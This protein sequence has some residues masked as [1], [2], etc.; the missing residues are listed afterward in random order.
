MPR[1]ESEPRKETRLNSPYVKAARYPSEQTAG[2]AYFLVQD[3]IFSVE[4]D[5]STY[6]IQLPRGVWHVA[7]VGIT[8]LAELDQKI[9]AIIST[10][11][12]A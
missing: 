5:L 9:T 8:P 6:R 2:K 7:V 12:Q 4:C 11:E 3:A 10:G 1:G